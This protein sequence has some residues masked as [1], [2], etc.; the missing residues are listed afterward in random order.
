VRDLDAAAAA[1]GSARGGQPR[2][3]HPGQH[4]PGDGHRPHRVGERAGPAEQVALGEVAAQRAQ[5]GVPGLVLHALGDHVS[6]QR[7][8]ER[9]DRLDHARR[10]RPRGAGAA[11]L[12]DERLVDLEQ[13]DRV[14]VQPG[15]RGVPGAEVVDRDADPEL[16][17]RPQ[18]GHGPGVVGERALRDLDAQP[19]GRGVV[20]REQVDDERDQVRAVLPGGELPRRDVHPD[21][22]PGAGAPVVCRDLRQRA[23]QRPGAELADQAG[24]LGHRDELGRRHGAAGAAGPA[25]QRL[26]PLDP[27]GDQV[28]LRLVDQRQLALLRRATQVGGHRQPLPRV[29]RAVLLVPLVAAAARGLRAVHRDVGAPQQLVPDHLA[30]LGVHD[31]DGAADRELL[32]PDRERLVERRHQPQRDLL[33]RRGG[34]VRQQDHELVAAEPRR[35]GPVRQVGADPGGGSLEQL[36]ADHVAVRVVHELEPVEVEQQQRRAGARGGQRGDRPLPGDVPVGEAGERV[37]RRGVGEPVLRVPEPGDVPGH[38]QHRVHGAVRPALGHRPDVVPVPA[39]VCGHADQPPGVRVGVPARVRRDRDH[40]VGERAHRVHHRGPAG[41]VPHEGAEVHVRDPG[42]AAHRGV[43]EPEPA[44]AVHPREGVRGVPGD[45]LQVPGAGGERPGAVGGELDRPE[46][47]GGPRGDQADDER[48]QHRAAEQRERGQR[49]AGVLRL[50]GQRPGASRDRHGDDERAARLRPGVAVLGE[51]PEHR[52]AVADQ[53]SVP[54]PGGHRV[55]QRRD[56]ERGHGPAEQA[57]STLPGAAGGLARVVHRHRDRGLGLGRAARARDLA[58]VGVVDRE[59]RRRVRG[60]EHRLAGVARVGE[61]AGEGRH[62][63][64]RR[65]RGRRS[66]GAGRATGDSRATGERVEQRGR[67]EPHDPGHVHVARHGRSP[68]RPQVDGA[69]AVRGARGRG[70]PPDPRGEHRPG[71][72]SAGRVR[73]QGG[74]AG[75]DPQVALPR[76]GRVVPRGAGGRGQE[77]RRR[78]R[79]PDLAT[80]PRDQGLR[81]DGQAGAGRLL[82]PLALL[83]R[84]DGGGEQ[85][86]RQPD[87][88]EH[89][90]DQ[91]H[92]PAGTTTRV[93]VHAHPL[94]GPAAARPAD[95]GPPYPSH[96]PPGAGRRPRA[97][98]SPGWRSGDHPSASRCPGAGPSHLHS[99]P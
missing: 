19:A 41:Q 80:E 28:H 37:V 29:V 54:R 98:S 89:G 64:V 71:P 10:A 66:R 67:P 40:V 2:A 7:P 58:G 78:G 30:G 3:D 24:L 59:R 65:S 88:H 27:A 60:A 50:R 57:P 70:Q 96:R 92:P 97:R 72:G 32:V 43:D 16:A 45:R 69:G 21:P 85:R 4:R 42:G 49:P 38:H 14:V 79:D 34:R 90:H 20:G 68:R 56:R 5:G 48:G 94:P 15:Q 46:L 35:D 83:V 91:P 6:A 31:S 11:E 36:V 22:Q 82:R 39:D 13:R 1:G 63:R 95:P 73:L 25:H 81:R 77:R 33:G 23:V 18:H 86:Q 84:V 75:Q 47:G 87:R 74:C 44:V 99:R 52:P 55:E 53:G 76:R 62:P 17:Q 9:D 8:A 26:D 61:R 12:L 51:H 93:V